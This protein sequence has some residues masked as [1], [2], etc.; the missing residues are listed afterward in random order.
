MDLPHV[1]VEGDTEKN[2]VIHL[3]ERQLSVNL[4]P[5]WKKRLR[6]RKGGKA[7]VIQAIRNE[8]GPELG[9]APVRCLV[10]RDLDE[11][12]G[13]SLDSIRQSVAETV[14][15]LFEERG[16]AKMPSLAVHPDYAN[17]FTWQSD[18]PDLR[19]ALHV[20]HYPSIPGL[21]QRFTKST[22]DDYVLALALHPR[23]ATR[24]LQ[25]IGLKSVGEAALAE[26]VRQEVPEL[27]RRN[28]I[29]MR[30]AKDYVRI[31]LATVRLG[32]S[33]AVFA[34]KLLLL[35]DEEEIKRVFAS[36]IA[37]LQFVVEA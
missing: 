13:E 22:T 20:A 1:F 10:M 21:S 6:E 4:N 32:M 2:V 30:E 37:A 19:L 7:Q 35:A 34:G 24:L 15:R 14:R 26:K 27:L 33:P 5:G 36:L 25:G 3:M 9:A 23:T 31:Y 28:G 12:E 11:D 29:R 16:F 17:V 8:L 18:E